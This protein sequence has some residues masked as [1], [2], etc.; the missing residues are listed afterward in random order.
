[1]QRQGSQTDGSGEIRRVDNAVEGPVDD[2]VDNYG[3]RPFS[4]VSRSKG[5]VEMLRTCDALPGMKS[6]KLE[7]R[8]ESWPGIG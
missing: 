2:Y 1:M 4:R 6:E 7:E 8:R 3:Q 5:S